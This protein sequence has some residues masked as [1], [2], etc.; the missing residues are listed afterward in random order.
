MILPCTRTVW[1]VAGGAP[2]A[3]VLGA[4]APGLWTAGLAWILLILLL[5]GADALLAARSPRFDVEAP[6]AVEVGRGGTVALSVAFDGARPPRRVE[7]ALALDAR[8]APGGRAFAGVDLSRGAGSATVPLVPVRRGAGRIEAAWL[9]WAGPLGLVWVQARRALALD[10]AVLTDVAAVRSPSAQLLI[11]DAAAGST[12][13][14]QRSEGSE[15]QALTD[16]EVGMDR[17]AIDWKGSARHGRLLAKEYRPERGNQIV[18]A[19]DAGRAMCEPLDGVPRVDRAVSAAMLAAYVA[20]KSGD[21]TS[22]FAFAA[23]PL[24]SSP[25]ASDTRGF[26]RLRHAAAAID[27]R[28][29]ETNYTLGLS[30]LAGALR[31]RSLIVVFTDFADPAGA[32]LMVAAAGRLLAR[33]LVLF[34]VMADAELE[35]IVDAE[36]GSVEDAG[37]AVTAAALLRTRRL[38]TTRLR[39]MGIDVVEAP[40]AQVGPRLINAYLSIKRRGRL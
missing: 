9:R 23:R 39:R 21:R 31:R 27:Y 22:L 24:V 14:K 5:A 2:A 16:Y 34:V 35:A 19:V 6:R 12:V 11:R 8:L 38:V 18:F 1:L 20:L 33:H 3:L 4:A 40:H 36:P 13:Q 10:V 37:R 7:A 17:R 28:H 15:F 29:E 32:E 30:T 25:F 26:G